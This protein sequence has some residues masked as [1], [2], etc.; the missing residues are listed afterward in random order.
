M[1]ASV[2]MGGK[3]GDFI[4]S[5]VFCDYL[6]KMYGKKSDLR[7]GNFGDDFFNGPIKTHKD[8]Y[9]IIINQPYINSFEVYAGERI[10]YNIS[11]FRSLPRLYNAGW[12]D[13]YITSYLNITYRIL[14]NIS[15]IADVSQK[16][17]DI[18]VFHRRPDRINPLIGKLYERLIKENECIFLTQ[19]MDWYERFPYAS[20]VKVLN[21][22]STKEL[23]TI[24][25][26]CKYYVGNQTAFT[27]IAHILNT[28]RLVECMPGLVDNI[29]YTDEIKHYTD[30][31]YFVS[32]NEKY[33][34]PKSILF[35]K[36]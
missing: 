1:V 7:I 33:I 36:N 35:T 25:N 17:R 29:H 31:S 18:V 26:S 3:F 8:L 14:D 15:L 16:Y 27:A 9:D 24:L 19:H 4:H 32:D 23:F 13:I 28:P 6:Y 30:M 21:P 34:A 5:L 11:E 22:T 10:D 12:T 20:Q 2:L